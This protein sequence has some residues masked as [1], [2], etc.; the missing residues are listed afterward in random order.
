MKTKFRGLTL[1]T[2]N[3]L[4]PRQKI[5]KLNSV[6]LTNTNLVDDILEFNNVNSLGLYRIPTN[7]LPFPTHPDAKEWKWREILKSCFSHS[8]KL[9]EK[10]NIRLSFHADEYT[11]INSINE[12]I[13]ENSYKTLDYLSDVLDYMNVHGNIVIHI[14]GV[15]G[16]KKSS[17]KRFI[18]NFYK[19]SKSVRDK[20]VIEN[21][22]KQYDWKDVLE[23]SN[24]IGV[25][26][27]LDIHHYRVNNSHKNIA[28]ENVAEIFSTWKGQ[29]PKIH[30][31]S[32]QNGIDSRAHA[33]YIDVNDFLWFFNLSKDFD[34]DIMLE[35]KAKELA[36]IKFREDLKRIN[37][38]L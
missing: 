35:A 10:Y 34:Y 19:L 27:V 11:I 37:I 9:A 18:E 33:D 21:D 12:A 29:R 1:K 30:V 20:I 24:E 8:G 6:S 2:L 3:Q 38:F 23:V 32:P 17:L 16:D 36:A 13:F 25:P 14:G 31:S 22:D 7:L 28:K 5:E 15:Y 26:M 4:N